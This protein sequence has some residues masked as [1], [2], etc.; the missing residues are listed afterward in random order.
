MRFWSGDAVRRPLKALFSSSPI[1][2][3][4]FLKLSQSLFFFF[5]FYF[6]ALAADPSLVVGFSV[7]RRYI[8]AHTLY[9]QN[10]TRAIKK[11]KHLK[12]PDR[13]PITVRDTILP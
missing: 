4:L 10:R 2:H 5:N 1:V 6:V 13:T 8:C 12:P 7:R 9:I 11:L 3:A